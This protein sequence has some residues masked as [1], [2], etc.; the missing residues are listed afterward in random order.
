[1]AGGVGD[2]ELAL[3]GGK[4]AVSHIDGDALLA[5]GAQ[6]V[7]QQGEI[8][9]VTLGAEFF[10]V[11]FELAKLVLEQRLGLIQQAADQGALAVVDTATGDEAQQLLVLLLLQVG[12][13]VVIACIG[14]RVHQKYPS[15]FFFS[16]EPAESLSIRR[17]WRSEVRLTSISLMIAGKLSASLSMAPV[18]G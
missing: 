2:D 6:A 11:G 15:C 12:R 16:M 8:Q 13:Q 1:M 7:D 5:L 18:N 10:R 17:P 3:V 14:D 4:E 9:F